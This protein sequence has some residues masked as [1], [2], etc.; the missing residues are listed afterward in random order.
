MIKITW[1]GTATI[2]IDLNGEKLLFDPFFR[3]NKKLEQPALQEFCNV[4]FIF[5]THAH[6]DHTFNLPT[7]LEH[8]TA[9][10]YAP[11]A[12]YEKLK[13]LGVNVEDKVQ[14]L[15]PNAML[16]T[17]NGTIKT[18]SS[19]HVQSNLFHA[20]LVALKS[21][22]IFKARRACKLLKTHKN[23]PMGNEIFA[24]EIECENKK[25][26]VF[27]SAGIDATKELPKDV[28]ILIWPFQ[29][30][31]N[32]TRYSIP[33]IEKIKPKTIILD[34]FDNAYPPITS[35]VNTKKFVKILGKKHPEIKVIVPQYHQTIKLSI[36]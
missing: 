29:G 7:I 28:D 30:K 1:F 21:I 23:Y 9:K 6:F 3:M 16:E 33:I 8:S 11:Y 13:T 31:M 18:F 27:G 14:V 15:K 17:K 25:I 2:L 19:K 35:N 32:M 34:H 24:Y 4:D 20:M 10:L 5:N 22:F 26:M 36:N 12:T